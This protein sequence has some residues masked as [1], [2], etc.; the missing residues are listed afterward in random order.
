MLF[1]R[2]AFCLALLA[3][4]P[5]AAQGLSILEESPDHLRKY[6]ECMNLAR[7]EPLKALPPAEKWHAQGGGLAAR[8][9]VATAMFGAG[10]YTQAAAQFEAIARDMGKDRPGPAR[11]IVG[12]GRPGL[13]GS[14]RC[15][16]RRPRR[17]AAPSSSTARTPICGSIAG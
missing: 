6:N 11:R 7:A 15:P 16:R 9:C 2:L 1:S 13:H 5:C 12:A 4:V 14:G 17:K 8:H 10:R 3:A